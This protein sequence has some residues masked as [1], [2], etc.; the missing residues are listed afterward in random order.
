MTKEDFMEQWGVQGMP[1]DKQRLANAAWD[2]ATKAEREECAKLCESSAASL[3]KSI[4]NCLFLGPNMICILYVA[5][6][7]CLLSPEQLPS[8]DF[9]HQWQ[10]SINSRV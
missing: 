1:L 7:V 5:V 4:P 10:I 9:C 3:K 8:I 6:I 2:D